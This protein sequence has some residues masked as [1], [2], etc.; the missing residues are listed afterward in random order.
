VNATE[1]AE[2]AVAHAQ[3]AQSPYEDDQPQ[4]ERLLAIAQ[5]EAIAALA[6]AVDRLAA[7]VEAR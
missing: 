6:A 4:C 3:N 2:I 5:V 1:R 7:A